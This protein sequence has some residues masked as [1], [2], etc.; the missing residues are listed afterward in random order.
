MIISVWRYSHLLLAVSSFLLLTLAS[1]TG[2][3]LAFEPIAD[4]SQSY[5]VQGSDTMRLA[6]VAPVVREQYKDV[7][8]LSV[9]DNEFVILD[10]TDT[11]GVAQKSYI[12]PR[13]GKIL[14][15]VKEQ[16]AF[17]NWVTAF[18]RSLFLKETG[19]FLVGLSSFLLILIGLSGVV[20]VIQ[21]QKGILR[22]FS[23][24]ERVNWAQYYHV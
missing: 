19:R 17:F 15:A 22:F 12:D 23:H 14:G 6:E 10:W 5:Y 7:Q 24:I 13:N 21:R 18:H 4:K 2:I 20:L 1:V 9:D 8:K 11:A 3:I 16:S